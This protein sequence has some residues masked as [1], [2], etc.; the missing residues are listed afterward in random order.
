VAT[1]WPVDDR[2][3]ARL[4]E[5]LYDGLDDGKA[6][7]VALQEAQLEIRGRSETSHPFYWAGFVAIGDGGTTVVLQRRA[8]WGHAGLAAVALLALIALAA[9]ARWLTRRRAARAAEDSRDFH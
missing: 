8:G 6:V 7:A 9:A 3:T 1:L 4:V 2:V 5:R